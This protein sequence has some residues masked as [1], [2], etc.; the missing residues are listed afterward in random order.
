MKLRSIL[1]ATAFAASVAVSPA[2][3][4]ESPGVTEDTIKLGILGSLTGPAAI[5][6]S[7]N[8]A[9]GVL[10]FEEANEAGGI[11]GRMLE[12]I[13]EDDETSP[14]KAIAA[15]KKLI[16]QDQVF[17][18]FGPAASAVSAAM[19]PAMSESGVPVFISVP[20]T[21]AVTEPMIH[22]V[23]RTGP[24]NDRMQGEAMADYVVDELGGERVAIIQQ[25]DE[26]GT[27]GGESFM[28]RMAD[29][30][31]QTVA[32]ETFGPGDTDF[33]SQ[34][35][36]IR[37]ANPDILVVY[38]YPSPSSIITRQT[39][40]LGMEAKIIGSNATSSRQYPE[41]VG[42][43]AAGVQNLITLAA[44][45][46]SDEPE[47]A[48]FRERFEARYPE[49]ARQNRPDLG[50]VLGYGGALVFIEGLRRAGD[51]LTR[52]GFIEALESLE[53]FETNL[54]LPT[55]FSEDRREGNNAARVVEI[56]EDLTRKLLPNTIVAD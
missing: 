53:D 23:F 2:S 13:V 11:N 45:P 55:T 26:Y 47:M 6:G 12:W 1:A 27:R 39:R 10:A 52:E 16:G 40:Q 37:D 41:I 50:D 44:L 35:L 49:L 48:A 31:E 51:D 3:A 32:Q 38:G 29:K 7:G 15:F 20:S 5:W 43:A 24:L 33:T 28:K 56:Q 18:V 14:P 21:P 22:N 8:F 4:Q 9:G 34:L 30:E 36:R 19:V 42:E 46:E 54:T 17:A 25:S